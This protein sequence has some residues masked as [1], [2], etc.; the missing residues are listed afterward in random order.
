MITAILMAVSTA[1]VYFP[2]SDLQEYLQGA[3]E[4]REWEPAFTLELSYLYL[5]F[6]KF[7]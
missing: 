7:F 1:V 3:I 5:L 4:F 2:W 6:E